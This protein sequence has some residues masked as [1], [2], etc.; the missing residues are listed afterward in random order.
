[1]FEHHQRRAAPFTSQGNALNDAQCNQTNRRPKTD[2]V[3]G[4]QH[5][6]QRRRAAHADHRQ[7]QHRFA[8]EPVAEMAEDHPADRPP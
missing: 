6:N 1:V 3:I 2:L 5:A 7:H 8:A 4:R